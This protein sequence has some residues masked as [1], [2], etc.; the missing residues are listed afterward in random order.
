MELPTVSF[1]DWLLYHGTPNDY[2]SD[3][4]DSIG[5]R[6][7]IGKNFC[8]LDVLPFS[9]CVGRNCKVETKKLRKGK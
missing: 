4:T 8:R 7:S 5:R 3:S 1:S 9:P 6:F 2:P